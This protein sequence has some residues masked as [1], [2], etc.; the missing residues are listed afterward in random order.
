[1]KIKSAIIVLL[2]IG[3]TAANA[4]AMDRKPFGAGVM[5]GE[6]TGLTFKFMLDDTHGVD[7]GGGWETS[8]DD[9]IY[10][11]ADYLYHLNDLITVPTGRLP[12]YFGG[13]LRFIDRD[14][15]DDKFGVRIPIGVEYLFESVPLGAF[16][17]AVP[18][19]NL[20]PDTDFDLEGGI[21]I[22]FFF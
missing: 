12:L 3:L 6:P 7:F 19:L 16:A 17:E 10:I 9:E 14:K 13:G 22:R 2:W 21:G 5:A 1:M 18:V 15:R 11:Y 8:G 4:A 20:N